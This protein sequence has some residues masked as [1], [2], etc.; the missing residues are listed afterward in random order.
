MYYLSTSGNFY[1]NITI[2]GENYSIRQVD[3]EDFF[4]L[5]VAEQNDNHLKF[6]SDLITELRKSGKLK[7][8]AIPNVTEAM[9]KHIRAFMNKRSNKH[10]Y[11]P[12]YIQSP[13]P[14][15]L[16]AFAENKIEGVDLGEGIIPSRSCEWM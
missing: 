11:F 13:I 15:E 10:S 12:V 1:D 9:D 2:T 16:I 8:R 5:T 6:A 3:G 7:I 14:S 4:I